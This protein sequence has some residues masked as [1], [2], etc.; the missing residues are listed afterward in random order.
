[1]W[2][3]YLLLGFTLSSPCLAQ[4]K[5][6]QLSADMLVKIKGH[7]DIDPDLAN[8]ATVSLDTLAKDLTNQDDRKAFWLNLYNTYT[9][10][11]LTDIKLLNDYANKRSRFFNDRRFNIAHTSISLKDI[12]HG[13]LRHSS[14]S[15]SQGR[16]RKLITRSI[17]RKLRIDRPIDYRIHAALNCGAHSC[18]PITIYIP[19]IVNEQL[20]F[21]MINYMA[22]AT[23]LK[24]GGEVLILPRVIYW[25]RG[26][27]GSKRELHNILVRYN[28]IKEIEN[29]KIKYAPWDWELFT[30]A[31]N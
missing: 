20:E 30:R 18:P 25:F 31:F 7:Q 3:I 2:F 28:V 5:Y 24:Q 22:D 8:L 14:I 9:Q 6:A 10:Y 19:R 4:S 26:D 12:E 21:A 29:P 13:M 23:Q 15:W 1:M 16:L 27:F 17:E 11:S